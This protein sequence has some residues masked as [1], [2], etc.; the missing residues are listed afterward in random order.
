MHRSSVAR[1]CA[2][3]AF[4]VLLH[5][6]SVDAQWRALGLSG[7]HVNRLVA[8]GGSLYACA[9]DGL[10]RVS[11]SA[12]DT[13]WTRVGF[14]GSNVLD[15]VDLGPTTLLAAKALMQ[16]QGDTVS[17]FR[18][19]DGGD[20]WQP[21]QNGFGAGTGTSGHQARRLLSLTGSPGTLL[22][23]SGR[24]EKSTDAGNSWRVVVE[25]NAVLNAIEQSPANPAMLWAGGESAIFWPYVL[26]SSDAGESW[27]QINL[28]AGG[29]NA[30]DAIAGHPTDSSV[31]YL[32]M[33][34]R[35]MKSGDAG[36]T[37]WTMTSPDPTIYTFGMA[38]R[39]SLPLKIYAAGASFT[40]P[41]GVVVHESLTGGLSWQ[42]FTYPADAG[43]GVNHL[44]LRVAD[45]EE[46]IFAATSNGVFSYSNTPTGVTTSEAVGRGHLRGEPNPFRETTAVE[47][48]LAASG[49]VSLEIID[50]HGRVVTTLVG[51]K[52]APGP[53][54]ASWSA[55]DAPAGIYFARLRSG[56]GVRSAKL[57]HLK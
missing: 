7:H 43:T 55:R 54:R 42:T 50:V 5:A 48:T 40:Q 16:A 24:I 10:Y 17:L 56:A 23:T 6:P 39:P 31:V 44:L 15:L 32:G 8:H 4:C 3:V 30:V 20:S 11:L 13:F 28:F 38:I 27:K 18:S 2:L 21:F 53:Y 34:G 57:L 52:L 22:A 1:I 49:H 36:T 35:V 9:T 51:S 29:D 26:K 12:P 25:Q 41:P 47:F 14:V 46:T 45:L 37:W 33:E 19:I